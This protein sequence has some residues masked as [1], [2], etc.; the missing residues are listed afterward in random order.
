MRDHPLLSWIAGLQDYPVLVVGD[1]ML[2]EYHWC[3]VSRI[4]PEA[5]VPVCKVERT[6]V[7][8]GGA[9]NVAQNIV[10][11]GSPAHLMGTIGK[12][13]SG[14][15]LVAALSEG[16][17]STTLMKRLGDRPTILKSR[18]VAH[19]QH[20]VRVDREDTTPISTDVAAQLWLTYESML[21]S[22]KMV[23]I[24]DYAKGTLTPKL[25]HKMIKGARELGVP[26]VVDP[27]GQDYHPYRGATIITPNFSEFCAAIGQ[28]PHSEEAIQKEGSKLLNRLKL[29]AL[30]ITR[31]EKGMTLMTPDRKLDIP[32]EAMQVYD[33]TGAGDTVVAI[34][35]VGLANG[36]PIEWA[37]R[38]A[39]AGAGVAVGRLGTAAVSRV[40]L[41]QS[42]RNAI[43]G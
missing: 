9:A 13:G 36:M 43:T 37:C 34:L 30:L 6:T 32:T 27:K 41:E 42:L 1:V 22:V 17:V 28:V 40:D 15:R 8:P 7:A 26:V 38:L 23:V 20:V 19:Q 35:A 10:T 31:S 12:D 14:D 11:F 21:A 25:I 4:S 16:G 3:S 2:D 5:P 18:I 29:D 24:S 39:N 33:I